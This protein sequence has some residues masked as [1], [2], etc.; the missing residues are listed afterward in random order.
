VHKISVYKHICENGKKKRKRIF[1]ANWAWGDS[2]QPGAHAAT[3]AG[4]PTRPANGS[5]A[6]MAPW[7]RAHV[8]VRRGMALGV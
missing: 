5:G 3:R 6:G 4:G 7:T 8:P 2:A 1:L